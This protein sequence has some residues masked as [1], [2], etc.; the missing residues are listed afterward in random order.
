M[1][2]ST[3]LPSPPSTFSAGTSQSWKTSSQ[4]FDPRMPSLSSFCEVE[5]PPNPRSTRKAVMP[6]APDS[7][8]GLRVDD[9]HVGVGPVGDPHLGAVE[10]VAVAALSGREPHA[11]HVRARARFAHRERADVLAR[12]EPR[13]IARASAPASRGVGSGSRTGSNAR[14]K[15]ARP[16][17]RRGLPLPSRRRARD[18]P[19]RRR[20]IPPRP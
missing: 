7:G 4:V 6:R 5:N 2:T 11:H 9:E 14:R 13:Q 10:H 12:D 1:R 8:V 15:R 3:P 18:S 20:P 17:P 19:C 16:K